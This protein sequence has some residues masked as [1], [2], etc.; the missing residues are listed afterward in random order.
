MS[1]NKPEVGSK[2]LAFSTLRCSDWSFA[3]VLD[4]VRRY[5]FNGI[6]FRGVLDQ[7]DLRQVPE[8]TPGE[9]ARTRARLQEAG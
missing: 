3:E 4:T 6:K 9:I 2:Q 7:V 8:F 5:R 1:E